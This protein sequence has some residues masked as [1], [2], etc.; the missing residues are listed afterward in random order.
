MVNGNQEI[1][2]TPIER[3]ITHKAK[4]RYV[5]EHGHLFGDRHNCYF[6]PYS[7]GPVNEANYK[8]IEKPPGFQ[9]G[10][11]GS[12]TKPIHE[13]TGLHGD[14]DYR[15]DI[16][17]STRTKIYNYMLNRYEFLYHFRDEWGENNWAID[18]FC[19]SSLASNSSYV[20]AG[21]DKA[22]IYLKQNE[23]G[24]R[25]QIEAAGDGDDEDDPRESSD[26]Y[27]DDYALNARAKRDASSA[28]PSFH[29]TTANR[30]SRTSESSSKARRGY[31]D[32]P[33]PRKKQRQD[34]EELSSSPVTLPPEPTA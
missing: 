9:V 27:E 6:N 18:A 17:I 16:A 3:L 33:R 2:R 32:N 34:L 20:R 12:D 23:S 25:G 15:L 29:S 14:Y 22:N 21:N 19:I 4:Y 10:R 1:Q 24:P 11:R 7:H 31:D 30:R 26:G 8:R 13:L 5:R 28:A